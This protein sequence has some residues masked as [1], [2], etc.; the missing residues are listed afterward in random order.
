MS[1]HDIRVVI[2]GGGTGGHLY[3]GIALAQTFKMLGPAS[4]ILF[5]GTAHGMEATLIPEKGFSF[6][7]I[8]AK[9][10]VG[11]GLLAR[12]NAL[13]LVPVGLLQAIRIL[14]SF[15]PH[16]VIGIGGYAAGPVLLAA[17]LLRIKRIILEP[18]L[19]PGLANKLIAPYVHFVVI[20]FDESRAYLRA[21][22][23]QLRGFPVRPE[24]VRAAEKSRTKGAV[25]TL[26]VLGGSQGAHTINRA[27]VEALP[28]FG[29]EK[30]VFHII[31]QTGKKD[32]EK[33]KEAYDRSGLSARVEPFIHDMAD[34]YA[35]ADLVISRAGAGTLS[36]LAVVRKPSIL[37]PFPFATGHQEKNAKA[38]VDSGAAEMI[39][40]RELTG[41]VLAE[42]VGSLLSD[43]RRLAE[44]ADAAGRRGHPRSAE[45]IAQACYELIGVD[46]FR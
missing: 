9:G 46:R 37:I 14:R 8:A 36:E 15:S 32:W 7:S 44:M 33:V 30:G 6:A 16:L 1:R 18:N 27:M 40:D 20:A 26:L 12:L 2:A 23:F 31:H 10:F 17:A 29:R 34:V 13:R 42:R 5:V 43:P 39:L 19:V 3:P 11:K 28:L 24:I 25:R 22:Q 4:Q 35:V 45:E 38:F 21:R 41:A